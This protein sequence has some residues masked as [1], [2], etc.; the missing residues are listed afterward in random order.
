MVLVIFET[1]LPAESS[2]KA[3]TRPRVQNELTLDPNHDYLAIDFKQDW[4]DGN[5]QSTPRHVW[6]YEFEGKR[7]KHL[8]ST[9]TIKE[10]V[11]GKVQTHAENVI[12][13]DCNYDPIPAREFTLSAFGFP[14]PPGLPEHRTGWPTWAWA[15]AVAAVCGVVVLAIRYRRSR[16]R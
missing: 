11:H 10:I 9:Q 6:D 4:S 5:A 2:S 13:T 8:I 1:D 15:L 16:S 12:V 3:A 7:I 14:E